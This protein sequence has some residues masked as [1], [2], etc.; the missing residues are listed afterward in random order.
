[1]LCTV[2]AANPS[3]LAEAN[4]PADQKISVIAGTP[5]ACRAIN[6]TVAIPAGGPA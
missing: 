3:V 5:T 6:G 2:P 4:A 1:V